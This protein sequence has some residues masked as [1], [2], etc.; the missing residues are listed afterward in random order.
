MEIIFETTPKARKEHQCVF[1]GLKIFKGEN[2]TNQFCKD[3]DVYTVKSH[4]SCLELAGK[5]MREN[6][7]NPSD[8]I[9]PDD[10][11][12]SIY[13]M[14]VNITSDYSNNNIPFE[15]KLKIV[16]KHFLTSR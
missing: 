1:C 2:Y 4:T 10:F 14:Y 11:Q 8:G 7:M 12:D 3:G 15:E 9:A 5:I 6:D 16:K 13:E